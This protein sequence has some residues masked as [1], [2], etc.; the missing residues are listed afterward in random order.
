[1]LEKIYFTVVFVLAFLVFGFS[2]LMNLDKKREDTWFYTTLA[3]LMLVMI[4]V[5]GGMITSIWLN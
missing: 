4:L 1:M 2:V 5:V 3:T